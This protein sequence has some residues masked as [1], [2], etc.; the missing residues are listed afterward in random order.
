V[1]GVDD[2]VSP[3]CPLLATD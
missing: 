3:E 2:S 1:M